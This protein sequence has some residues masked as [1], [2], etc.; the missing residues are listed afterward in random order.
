MLKGKPK[1]IKK[2][3]DNAKDKPCMVNLDCCNGNSA[4]TVLAHIYP[5]GTNGMGMKG[6][7]L[8]ATWACSSCHD[9]LDGRVKSNYSREELLSIG[10]ESA[11]KTIEELYHDGMITVKGK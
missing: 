2:L 7:D 11:L 5:K 4:T 8:I 9:V 6:L 1:K 3:R 10:F